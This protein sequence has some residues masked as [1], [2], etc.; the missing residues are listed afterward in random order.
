VKC[1]NVT[2]GLAER[3]EVTSGSYAP[4]SHEGIAEQS[5]VT[6]GVLYATNVT[7]RRS[8]M[9]PCD[10]LPPHAAQRHFERVGRALV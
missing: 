9:P 8:A 7:L 1:P 3:S 4:T 2:R 10:V 5:K 6:L